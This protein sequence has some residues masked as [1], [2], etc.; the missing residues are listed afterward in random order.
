VIEWRGRLLP[1]EV[2]SSRSVSYAETHS[3]RTFLAEYPEQTSGGV[4]LY[5]GT[6]KYWLAEGILAVP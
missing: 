3:L 5:D 1:V 4:M 6:G 2:K